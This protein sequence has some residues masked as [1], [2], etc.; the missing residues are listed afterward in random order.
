VKEAEVAR[1]SGLL[2]SRRELDRLEKTM[3]EHHHLGLY[4][5]DVEH[6]IQPHIPGGLAK[7]LVRVAKALVEGEL[8]NLGVKCEPIQEST[9]D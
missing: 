2:R 1:A 5:P 6:S 7:C 3:S 8:A 4:V 9:D